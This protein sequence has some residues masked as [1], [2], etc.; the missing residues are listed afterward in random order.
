MKKSVLK[1]ILAGI[2][3]TLSMAC[4]N[5]KAISTF[6]AMNTVMNIQTYGSGAKSANEKAEQEIKRLENLI[7]TTKQTSDIY[8]INHD[9]NAELD[10]EPESLELLKFSLEMAYKTDGALNPA[11]YPV[12]CAWGFTNKNYRV[13]SQK[14]IDQLLP[15]TDYTKIKIDNQ[16]VTMLPGMQLDFGATGKGFA[17]DKVIELLKTQG[18]K[19]AL[20]DLGGNIQALGSK[21]DGSEW[22]IG[23]K[24][25]W[26]TNAVLGIK[27]KDQAVITSGGYER[28]FTGDDGHKYIHIFDPKTGRPVEGNLASVTIVAKKGIYADALSTAL[29]VMGKEKATEYW[30]VQSKIKGF[31]FN[32]ILITNQKELIYT[33]PLEEKLIFLED[34]KT[35][36]KLDLK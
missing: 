15:L 14:E 18:I 8:K 24:S 22:T 5:Q 27:V 28:N 12:T 26:D 29:F 1:S 7:S 3:V 4:K 23:I 2:L 31:E 20:L 6:E 17:G 25:P 32:M 33:A 13:P 10:F 34:F 30:K 11:L 9:K 36:T 16:T 35:V 21:T 19:S